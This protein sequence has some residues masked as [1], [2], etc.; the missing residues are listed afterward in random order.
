MATKTVTTDTKTFTVREI[1]IT[2]MRDWWNRIT[3]PGHT[4]DV[5]SEFAVPGISLNDLAALCDCPTDDFNGLTYRELEAILTAAKELNP[6][7][8]RA[9]DL[10]NESCAKIAEILGDAFS[11]LVKDELQ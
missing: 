8:F 11:G 9:R 6:H 5:V 1:S 10:L 7:M 2:E 3:M 4:C